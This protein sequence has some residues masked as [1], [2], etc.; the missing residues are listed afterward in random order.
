M[1]EKSIRSSS[2]IL[3][4]ANEIGKLTFLVTVKDLVFCFDDTDLELSVFV[5]YHKGE[6]KVVKQNPREASKS[7]RAASA[8]S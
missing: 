1:I 3:F 6:R 4:S 2:S 7:L 5:N 8:W